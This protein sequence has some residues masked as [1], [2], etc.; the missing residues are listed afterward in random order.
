[1][2]TGRGRELWDHTGALLATVVGLVGVKVSPNAINPYRRES[3]ETTRTP[4]QE[5]DRKA[6]QTIL[7]RIA[8]EHG[9]KAFADSIR[10]S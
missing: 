5:A 2:T 7:A 1:M 4:E 6:A 9:L 8:V 3:A 10:G